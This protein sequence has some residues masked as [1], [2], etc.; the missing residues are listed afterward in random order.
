MSLA[1]FLRVHSNSKEVSYL[2]WQ[3]KHPNLKTPCHF[4]R[5]F[6]LWTKRRNGLLL[7]KYLI[8]LVATLR[9]LDFCS[10]SDKE[11]SLN[12]NGVVAP[13]ES[14]IVKSTYWDNCYTWK[15]L[16]LLDLKLHL[17]CSLDMDFQL[18]WEFWWHFEEDCLILL[19]PTYHQ[20]L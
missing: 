5:K 15:Q 8:S 2:P 19:T 12:K 3:S 10:I 17:R 18:C 20:M 14:L 6:F 7:V 9:L 13:N 4:K 16:Y 1:T 11:I